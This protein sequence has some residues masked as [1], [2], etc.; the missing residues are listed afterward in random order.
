MEMTCNVSEMMLK[1]ALI[2]GLLIV[3]V[4]RVGEALQNKDKSNVQKLYCASNYININIVLQIDA[5]ICPA[6]YKIFALFDTKPHIHTF[7]NTHTQS[8]I[9]MVI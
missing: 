7:D 5:E 9:L 8:Q 3:L 6:F 1:Q 4:W 2:I